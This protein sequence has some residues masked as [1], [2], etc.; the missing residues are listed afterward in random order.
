MEVDLVSCMSRSM[1]Q[2]AAAVYIGLQNVL[3]LDSCPDPLIW[4]RGCGLGT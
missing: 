4:N 2:L 3:F 1:D